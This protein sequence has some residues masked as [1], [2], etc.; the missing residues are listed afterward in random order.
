M[1]RLPENPLIR[2][3]DV[4]PSRSDY[5]VCGAFNAGVARCGEDVLLLLRVAERPRERYPDVAV[6]PI[7]NHEKGEVECFEVRRGDP[8]LDEEDERVF[9]YKG[10]F[11]LTSLSHL[12]LARSRDGIHFTIDEQPAMFPARRT[13]A[14]GLEDPRITRIGEDHWITYKAVSSHGITT[15][16]A[17]TRDFKSYTRHG[18]IFCPE[19]LDVVLFPETFDGAY[20]AWTRPVGRHIGLPTI[21]IARSPDLLHWGAHEPVLAPRPGLWDGARVGSSCVPFKTEKGW[22]EIYHGADPNHRYCVGA[23]LIDPDDP[24]NVRA[25]SREPLMWPEASYEVEGFFSQVV[26]PC[27]A[28]VRDDGTVYVYY[29]A[30]DECTCAA[31][32]S[33][34]ALLGHLADGGAG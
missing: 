27:G 17:R 29:G 5:E 3:A 32:T 21:W 12:R 26:F 7:W 11:Y 18:V 24:A 15:A 4:P 9:R 6:A 30:S 31:V 23:A 1:R 2:P 34:D 13:E 25:R 19:N 33:V 16:L 10:D 8:D 20:V 28:D 14:F 22:L